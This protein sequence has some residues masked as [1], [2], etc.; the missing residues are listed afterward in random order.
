[1]NR[2][3]AGASTPDTAT[4]GHHP[5]PP[6]MDHNPSQP[7]PPRPCSQVMSLPPSTDSEA[8]A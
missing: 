8:V 2:H 7:P 4:P 5:R 1:M 6:W 3:I